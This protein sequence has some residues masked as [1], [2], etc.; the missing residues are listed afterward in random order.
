MKIAYTAGDPAGIGYEIYAKSK[1]QKLDQQLGIELILVDDEKELS[2][3]SA[4]KPG[5]SAAAGTHAYKTLERAHQ[6]ALTK[7][8]QAIITGPV[9]KG[10]LNM[11]GYKF[12]GQTE[13]LAHL[14]GLKSSDIEMIFVYKDFRT[15]LTTRHIAISQV[16]AAFASRSE[17]AIEHAI[18]ACTDLFKIPQPR[19]ALAGLNPHAGEGGL[20]GD[21]ETSLQ[22]ML[23]QLRARHPETKISDYMSADALFAQAAQ[24]LL[25]ASLRARHCEPEGRSNP[26]YDMYVAAY[27]DQALPLIKG[28]SGYSAVN[29]SYG[30]PYLRVS[31]DHGTGFDI[32]G[33]GIAS[34]DGLIACMQLITSLAPERETNTGRPRLA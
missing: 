8:V 5:P 24:S 20:F 32:A 14:N 19:I 25:S 30:L 16:P 6:M 34:E 31:M 4:L 12:S 17:S 9:A 3:F 2:K 22:P 1:A 29:L 28:I 13:V 15:L 10:S 7:E 11:A 23:A 18:S 27:H 26:P 33:R 21:E